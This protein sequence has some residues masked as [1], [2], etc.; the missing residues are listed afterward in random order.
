M[1]LY[2]SYMHC[3]YSKIYLQSL[4]AHKIYVHYLPRSFKNQHEKTQVQFFLVHILA[5]LL[6]GQHYFCLVALV[7]LL[8]YLVSLLGFIPVLIIGGVILIGGNIAI[9]STKLF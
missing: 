2:N 1:S 4:V 3:N 5:F 7:A 6:E 9:G 8:V